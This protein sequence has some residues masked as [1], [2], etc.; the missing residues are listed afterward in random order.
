MS[1]KITMKKIFFLGIFLVQ[2]LSHTSCTEK[3]A[4]NEKAN[5]IDKLVRLFS[6]YDMFNGSVLVVD[7]G[8]IIYKNAFGLPNM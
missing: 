7:N 3:Q 5:K 1:K 4:E 8:E 6:E 2:I